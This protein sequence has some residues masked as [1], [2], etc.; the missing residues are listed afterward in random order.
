MNASK[1][2]LF[3]INFLSFVGLQGIMLPEFLDV[4]GTDWRWW[5]CLVLLCTVDISAREHARREFIDTLQKSLNG[6]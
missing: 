4:G 5:V 2:P 6:E 1:T 3:W